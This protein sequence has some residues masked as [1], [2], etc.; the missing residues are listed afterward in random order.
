[1]AAAPL[2]ALLH[3]EREAVTHIAVSVGCC[4]FRRDS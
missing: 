4:A 1:M 2:L 3:A